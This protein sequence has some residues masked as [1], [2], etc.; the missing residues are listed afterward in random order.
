MSSH[1]T[2]NSGSEGVKNEMSTACFKSV[3]IL[4]EI[5]NQLDSFEVRGHNLRFKLEKQL[6]TF[7]E[8]LVLETAAKDNLLDHGHQQ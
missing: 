5:T 6:I 1:Q 3:S 2:K 8:M 4:F 7:K